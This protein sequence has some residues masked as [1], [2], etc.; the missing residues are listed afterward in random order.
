[1]LLFAKQEI[2]S[3]HANEQG[4]NHIRHIIQERI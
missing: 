2:G 4:W 3:N 1:M